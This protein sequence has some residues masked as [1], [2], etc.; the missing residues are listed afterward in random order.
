MEILSWLPFKTLQR[1]KCVC[2]LWR[3]LLTD[4]SYFG[5]LHC[6]RGFFQKPQAKLQLRKASLCNG[7]YVI[8]AGMSSWYRLFGWYG[9]FRYRYRS[10]LVLVPTAKAAQKLM[11]STLYDSHVC[12]DG[13]SVLEGQRRLLSGQKAVI[14]TP[15]CVFEILPRHSLGPDCVKQF[16]LYN[17]AELFARGFK[18]KIYDIFKLLPRKVR[19]VVISD[20]MPREALDIPQRFWNQKA[21]H[22]NIDAQPAASEKTTKPSRPLWAERSARVKHDKELAGMKAMWK[23]GNPEQRK[24]N[25][26]VKMHC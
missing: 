4:D 12:I 11:M 6:R 16:V 8:S 2:K 20:R 9:V 3:R 23:L 1:F 22:W 17:A 19:V 7:L 26:H 21:R 25:P 10:T 13:N 18:D 24:K 15:G 5:K 14:G